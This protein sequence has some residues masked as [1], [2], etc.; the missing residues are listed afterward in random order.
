MPVYPSALL[1][2]ASAG[3]ANSDTVK[4]RYRAIQPNL[5]NTSSTDGSYTVQNYVEGVRK[6]SKSQNRSWKR[7]FASSS[8]T[9]FYDRPLTLPRAGVQ[10]PMPFGIP[11]EIPYTS[12]I[13]RRRHAL[14]DT[15]IRWNIRQR[16]YGPISN[17]AGP[18]GNRKARSTFGKNVV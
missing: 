17:V 11:A 16:P 6:A 2:P 5:A 3:P 10:P 18:S 9:C 1:T 15:P 4:R 7:L 8:L 13:P 12:H 14:D